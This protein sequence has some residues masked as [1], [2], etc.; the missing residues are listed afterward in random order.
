M[1]GRYQ[2]NVSWT[3]LAEFY[4]LSSLPPVGWSPSQNVSPTH[5]APVVV[6]GEGGPSLRVVRWGFPAP[7]LERSGKD[8]WSRALINARSED[9]G[10]RPTW[11]ASFQHQRCLVPATS[12]IEWIRREGARY[13]VGLSLQGQSIASLGGVWDVHTRNGRPTPVC[14]ILTTASSTDLEGIHDRMP[15]HVAPCDQAAWLDP[16]TPA[17]QVRALTAPLPPGSLSKTP[18]PRALNRP[19]VEPA[20]EDRATWTF[21]SLEGSEQGP[22]EA[23]RGAAQQS[24]LD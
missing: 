19:G 4:G 8:P 21:A 20:P 18:L 10:A 13:P 6:N 16:A 23:A 15:V 1:C 5:G 17:A 24:L 22:P 3:S 7:W 2:L 14:A 12:F 9:A 11:R